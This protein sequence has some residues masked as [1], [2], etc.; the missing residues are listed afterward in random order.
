MHLVLAVALGLAAPPATGP[1]REPDDA[2]VT[3]A[4]GIVWHAQATV[5]PAVQQRLVQELAQHRGRPPETIVVDASKV[6]RARVAVELPRARAELAIAWRRRLDG[7][8]AAYRAGQLTEA[9]EDLD[10]LVEEI[11]T[12]PVVPG[13]AP[14][15]WRAHVLEAQLAWIEGD[16]VALTSAL[17]SAVAL[18]P[19]ASPSTREVPPAVVEA[20]E[21]ERATVLAAA[22]SW[23]RLDVDLV[24]PE[25][26]AIEIDGIV[27]DRPVPAG[28][29]LVVV[30][31]PGAMPVG[32]VLTTD[33]RWEVPSAEVIL[34]PRL[35]PDASE[36]ERICQSAELD[37]LMLV[38]WRG[39]RLALQ[40]YTCGDGFGPAWYQGRGDWTAGLE[41]VGRVPSA[42]WVAAPV[43]HLESAWPKIPPLR[44][45][46]PQVA[47]DSGSASRRGRWLRALP[48]MLIGGAI[49]GGVTV[50][51]L[52]ARD[53]AADIAIDGDGFLRR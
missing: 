6:A 46:R 44:R 35:P 31:R 52:V 36:A 39:E 23:P 53:P 4:V 29:H 18:D 49:A 32:A 42:G 22:A 37:E 10:A 9:A 19:Q 5:T 11:R 24:E 21:A 50:G 7:V 25:P 13:A 3:D 16:T 34:R 8:I 17:A 28:E 47:S 51:V 27:G 43:L 41:H 20:Y 26:Y 48:W 33:A 45:R 15:A 14:L 40:R 38:R 1:V 12:D 30:R 2:T